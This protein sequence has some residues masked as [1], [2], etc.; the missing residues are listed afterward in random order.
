MILRRGRKDRLLGSVRNIWRGPSGKSTGSSVATD[1]GDAAI[2]EEPSV[3]RIKKSDTEMRTQSE[4]DDQGQ[5]VSLAPTAQGNKSPI[6]ERIAVSTDVSPPKPADVEVN[7]V[8]RR[9]IK[10]RLLGGVR[11]I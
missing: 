8:P 11:V 4:S 9:V 10:D 6:F 7:V 5:E 2:D 1:D 3:S